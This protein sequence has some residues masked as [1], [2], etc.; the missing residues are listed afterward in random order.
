[1][2]KALK[3]LT[4]KNFFSRK[5]KIE[6]TTTTIGIDTHDIEYLDINKN[7]NNAKEL[8]ITV[9]DFAG[10]MEYSVNHQ[11]FSC[12]LYLQ[13]FI[14]FESISFHHGMLSMF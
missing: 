12:L 5:K 14:F 11:V 9:W 13:L 4:E 10:Q 7:K 8:K 1:L 6:P 2:I 3:Q